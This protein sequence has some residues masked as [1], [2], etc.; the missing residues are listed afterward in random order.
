MYCLGHIQISI[1]R[2]SAQVIVNEIGKKLSSEN[3]HDQASYFGID[4]DKAVI[5]LR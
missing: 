3:L 1:V 5:K 4:S 2:S